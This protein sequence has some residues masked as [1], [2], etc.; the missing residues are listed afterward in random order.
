VTSTRHIL[1]DI[2]FFVEC[3]RQSLGELKAAAEAP[4]AAKKKR[5]RKKKAP[6]S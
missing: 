6:S 4:P 5:K 1:P 3:L 2:D